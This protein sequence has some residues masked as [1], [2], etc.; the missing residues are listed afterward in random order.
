MINLAVLGSTRGSN[1]LPLIAASKD[2]RMKAKIKLVLSNKNDALILQKAKDNGIPN[3]FLSPAGMSRETYDEQI[4][5][6]LQS[7][8]IDLIVLTG[9]MR[10]LSAKFVRA[11]PNQIINVHPSLLPDFSGLMDL[12]VHKA[13]LA[14]GKRVSGCTVHYVSEE[15][16]EGPIICQLKCPVLPY[17][18]PELLKTRLQTLEAKALIRAINAHTLNMQAECL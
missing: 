8:S 2:G 15:V 16:D 4:S 3:Y 12:E 14:A 18:T 1:L 17:D 6:L 9:Y 11:W 7:H 10:I 5:D 13:V